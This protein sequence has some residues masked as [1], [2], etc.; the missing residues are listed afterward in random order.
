MDRKKVVC[1]SSTK[2][3]EQERNKFVYPIL[4]QLEFIIVFIWIKILI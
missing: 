3:D 1:N 2:I 4:D